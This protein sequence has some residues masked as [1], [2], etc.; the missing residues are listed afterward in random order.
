MR[1]N[2]IERR[3]L[4]KRARVK[5][6]RLAEE[7]GITDSMIHQVLDDQRHTEWVRKVIAKAAK[8]PVEKLWPSKNQKR[9]AA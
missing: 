4:L 6:I 2:P 3:I 7:N 5:I 1:M 9:K 8:K